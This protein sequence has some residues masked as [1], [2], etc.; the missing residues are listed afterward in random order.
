[1]QRTIIGIALAIPLAFVSA[2]ADAQT[3]RPPT[4]DQRCPSKWGAGDQRGAGNHAKPENVLRAVRLIR[5]GEVIELGHVLSADMPISSTRQFNMHVKRTFMNPQSNRRGSNEEIV[6]SE[7]GQVGTQFDGFAHQTIGD[8]LYN[9]F[10]QDQITTRTGFS[11]LGIE[12]V[13]ALVTRGVL[14]DV[15]GLKSVDMLPDTYEITVADLQQALQ[16]QSLTLQPGDA[17]IIH[18]GW[19]KLWGKDNARYMKGCPGIGVAAAEWLAKQDPMLV[20]SDNF[21]VE[22]SPNPDPQISA[23]VHQIFLVVN[24]IH[25]LENL[26]L[27]ELAAKRVNEFAFVIQPLKLKGAT[28]STVAPIAVR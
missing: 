25:I 5:T 18:T 14:I 28:G 22:V 12:N 27:D 16:R 11:K 10:K 15:A 24:G 2:L 17:V 23:P 8:S 7:I 1:M 9:C 6:L 21:P 20:G 3:W 26:K 4:D 19:G 13:G